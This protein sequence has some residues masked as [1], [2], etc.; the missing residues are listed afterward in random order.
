MG[1][2]LFFQAGLIRTDNG[3][4]FIEPLEKGQQDVEVK[5]RVH[6]V[7]RRSAIKRESGQRREDLHNEGR[8]GEGCDVSGHRGGS[9]WR[10]CLRCISL[11][12]QTV[13]R[14]RVVLRFLGFLKVPKKGIYETPPSQE[15]N[16][17]TWLTYSLHHQP[18]KLRY[19]SI[20]W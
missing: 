20:V 5:G 14:L 7:Y 18:V 8:Q 11:D 16:N 19:S 3:E 17:Y 6:V 13:G 15:N 2:P 10:V 1:K 12:D 9:V 4:F